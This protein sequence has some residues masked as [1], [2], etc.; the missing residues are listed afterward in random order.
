MKEKAM[1]LLGLVVLVGLISMFAVSVKKVDRQENNN[2]T[3]TTAEINPNT[4]INYPNPINPVV[5]TD[6]VEPVNPGTGGSVGSTCQPTGCS[7]QVCSDQD[8]MTTCEFREEY[9]CFRSARCERQVDGECGWTE[10]AEYKQCLSN[11]R[12]A[13]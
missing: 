4:P 7:G 3:E 12:P 2:P 6:P 13:Y 8:V 10:T 1:F 11:L 9:A 5:P